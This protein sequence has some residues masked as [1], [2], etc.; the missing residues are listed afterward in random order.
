LSI[1]VQKYGGTS[2]GS[3]ERIQEVAKRI[4]FRQEEGLSL[5]VVVS[6]MAGETDRLIGLSR[7]VSAAPALREYDV[8]LASGEQVSSALLAMALQDLGVPAR[9]FLGFQLPIFT[10]NTHSYAALKRIEVDE[11]CQSLGQGNVAVVAGFQGITTGGD[12]TTLGR[13]GSDTT[14]VALAAALAADCCEIYTDVDGIYTCDP[15]VYSRARKLQQIA[16]D[17]MME[18]AVLGAKVL[19]SRSVELAKKYKVNVWVRSSF[20]N[21]KGTRVCEGGEIMEGA[22]VSGIT[23]SKGEA[24]ISVLSVPDRPGVAF[25]IFDSLAADGI[26]VDMIIQNIGRSNLTDLTFTIPAAELDRAVELV[27]KVAAE[28]G[29]QGVLTDQDIAKISIVG[30][31]MQ[32]HPGV[33]SRMF[34]AL[35]REGINIIMISTSEIKISCI[36]NARYTEL[37]VRVLHDEFEL[38]K[39]PGNNKK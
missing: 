36:I 27:E 39:E 16:Y 35:A 13:G 4:A 32:S 14:A 18:L 2:V 5:A 28:I 25:R 12:I 3:P 24:R 34:G 26:N 19:H 6:A 1:I 22:L 8:M 21:S 9:S 15:N 38:E 30:A 29:A 17:E 7:E 37:A 31:G 33:A 11:L 20:N 10:D 23:Y